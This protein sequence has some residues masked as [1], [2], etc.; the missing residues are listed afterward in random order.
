MKWKMT[1][2][3]YGGDH[4]ITAGRCDRRAGYR[5][6]GNSAETLLRPAECRRSRIRKTQKRGPPPLQV[7]WPR[8][9]RRERNFEF[10]SIPNMECLSNTNKIA[11]P[12]SP[13]SAGMRRDQPGTRNRPWAVAV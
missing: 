4:G 3:K 7:S 11:I 13:S 2:E 1:N 8:A 5:R 9:N 12:R 6:L 10:A